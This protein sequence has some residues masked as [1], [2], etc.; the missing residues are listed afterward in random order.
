MKQVGEHGS[1]TRGRLLPRLAA[2]GVLAMAFGAPW[3]LAQAATGGEVSQVPCAPEE[4]KCVANDAQGAISVTAGDIPSCTVGEWVDVP[5]TIQATTSGNNERLDIGAWFL[6]STAGQCQNVMTTATNVDGQF[7]NVDGDTCGDMSGAATASQIFTVKVQCNPDANGV[8]TFPTLAYW[9][10]NKDPNT[11]NAFPA[12]KPKCTK[13]ETTVNVA[14]IKGKITVKKTAA[15]AGTLPFTFNVTGGTTQTFS[16]TAGGT[17]KVIEVNATKT[18]VDYTITETVPSGWQ[19]SGATCTSTNGGTWSNPAGS[20][21]V[22]VPVS[23]ANSDIS[24]EFVNTKIPAAG[25]VKLVK[26]L[27]D[28]D[29]GQFTYTLGAAQPTAPSGGS[30]DKTS[31]TFTEKTTVSFSEA[32]AAGTVLDNYM[33]SWRCVRTDNQ[34]EIAKSTPLGTAP[35]GSFTMPDGAPPVVCTITN[36]RQMFKLTLKKALSPDTDTGK[37][38]LLVNGQGASNVGNGGEYSIN[39]AVGSQV[40]ISETEGANTQLANYSSQ[41]ACERPQVVNALRESRQVLPPVDPVLDTSA[42][43]DM[44]GRNVTCTF[45]NTRISAKLKVAKAWADGFTAGDKATVTT[46]GFINNA[47]SGESIAGTGTTGTEVT[48]YAGETGQL[49]ETFSAGSMANYTQSYACDAEVT[50][51]AEGYVSISPADKDKAITCTLTNTRRP[52]PPAVAPIPTTSP[53]GLAALALMMVGVAGWAA[54]RRS[55]RGK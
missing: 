9:S 53:E 13:S 16:L 14:A 32:A 41:L 35:S 39:V 11:C 48:V 20:S 38:N 18:A 2:L 12:G 31:G 4:Y 45:T 19:F 15:D 17:P 10:N 43:F 24:C 50:A 55:K 5:V 51:D 46:T 27:T 3:P 42:T 25:T 36:N 30:G 28:G 37:F 40:T 54:R 52:A 44:P 1:G 23:F 6:S 29:P 47:S 22:T 7:K 34:T 8:V 21:A 26:A 49:I 33:V